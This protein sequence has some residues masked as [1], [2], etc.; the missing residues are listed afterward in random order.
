MTTHKS[1][2]QAP[3]ATRNVSMETTCDK[4]QSPNRNAARAKSSRRV[5]WLLFGV[6][7]P[8]AVLSRLLPRRWRPFQSPGGLRRSPLAEAR[9][10]AHMYAPFFFMAY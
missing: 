10:A 4:V 3:L 9:Q 6:F 1:M 2:G 5:T 7:L 8:I